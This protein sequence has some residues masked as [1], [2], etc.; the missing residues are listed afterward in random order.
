MS[1]VY[2]SGKITGLP[3]SEYMENFMRAE[4]K[5]KKAGYSVINPA[6]IN[7]MLPIDT[8]WEQYMKVSIT[9]LNMCDAIY[10]MDNWKDSR[11]AMMEYDQA[12]YVGMKIIFESEV[13]D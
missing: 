6:K 12:R 9:L 13:A 2:I 4:Q 10:M 3:Q 1:K 7:A 11:G 5:M 8:T